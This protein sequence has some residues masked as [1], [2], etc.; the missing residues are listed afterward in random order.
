MKPRSERLRRND[1]AGF[2]ARV[3][4][5]AA[6]L[7]QVRGYHAT[8][9]QDVMQAA[10]ATGG[11]LHHHFPTKKSLG[12]AVIHDRVALAVRDTWIEPLRLTPSLSKAIA[13]VF[14][15]IIAGV[16][17]RARVNGC[18]LNNLALELSLTDAE[19]REAINAIF[20][21]WQLAL[22]QRL[23]A[24]RGGACLARARRMEAAQFIVSVYSGAMTMAKSSQSSTPLV[25]AAAVLSRWLRDH[26]YARQSA[27]GQL[28]S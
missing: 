4:D 13:T 5:T 3:L 6:D 11:A 26:D 14:A 24:T 8:T 22:A 10:G 21:A 19:F 27:G 9:I 16:E 2:R 23:R 12:L 25:S 18:P 15:S 7:F 20:T 1:P 17:T 28:L